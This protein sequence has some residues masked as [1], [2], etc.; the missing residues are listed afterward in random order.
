MVT[1]INP[2]AIAEIKAEDVKP[3]L[4]KFDKAKEQVGLVVADLK[5]YETISTKEQQDLAMTA[6]KTASEVDKAIEK[7]RKEL[8]GPF[9]D[10]AKSIN[11]YVKELIA[12]LEPGIE[13]VKKACL[14]YQEELRKQAHQ[15]MITQRQGDLTALGF[16]YDGASTN[17]SLANV[18]TVSMRE[19][20]NY[21]DKT[22]LTIIGGF[23]ATIQRN[24]EQFKQNLMEE[25]DLVDAF[26]TEEQKQ[27]ITTQIAKADA[28]PSIP[29][30]PTNG[31]HYATEL[32]GT[33]NRWTFEITSEKDIPREYLQVNE[34]AIREAIKA[35]V[36]EIPGV[37]IFQ[38]QSLTIR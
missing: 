11:N 24:N 17:F 25:V 20:E 32:K 23:Q 26:G 1:V 28:T 31:F 30:R 6:L 33:T 15:A 4:K 18:G 13:K 21:D 19:L 5:Q 12:E 2:S 37:R 34:T 36:R 27:D 35:G 22:W 38:S 16:N 10:A 9:N 29:A 3:D 8:V 14:N 7:K